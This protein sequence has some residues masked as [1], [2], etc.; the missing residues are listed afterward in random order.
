ML[1]SSD[2]PF[3]K[4]IMTLTDGIY[5]D[6]FGI[7]GCQPIAMRNDCL[8]AVLEPLVDLG[9]IWVNEELKTVFIHC[10]QCLDR[11]TGMPYTIHCVLE[12]VSKVSIEQSAEFTSSR[13]L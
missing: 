5:N 2:V 4:E 10:Q 3:Y 8:N 6:I 7:I 13:H 11:C 9:L 1:E 12:P